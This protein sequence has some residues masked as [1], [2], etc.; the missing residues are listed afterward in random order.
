MTRETVFYLTVPGLSTYV[1][2]VLLVYYG[3]VLH[4]YHGELTSDMIGV[5]TFLIALFYPIS[6]TLITF[7]NQG[8]K[9]FNLKWVYPLSVVPFFIALVLI[10]VW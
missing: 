7:G 10:V 9:F 8:L 6:L 3:P 1:L 5:Y 2:L 4:A